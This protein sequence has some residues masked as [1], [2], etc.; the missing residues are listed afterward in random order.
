MVWGHLSCLGLSPA[1]A[2]NTHKI[3]S[4]QELLMNTHSLICTL[5]LLPMQLPVITDLRNPSLKPRHWNL[6]EEII[7]HKF[8]PN[9]PLTL[10]LMVDL[11]VFEYAE[12]IR[13]VSGQASSEASLEA[14][15]KKVSHT[16]SESAKALT[17]NSLAILCIICAHTSTPTCSHAH[18]AYTHVHATHTHTHAPSPLRLKM[19]GRLLSLLCFHTVSPRMCLSLV[20]QM[21]SKCCWMTV[22]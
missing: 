3:P 4:P 18:H 2:V 17:L 20:G 9:V 12:A 11:R 14:I 7:Q 5:S 8:D 10:Q 16:S 22:R 15:L 6:I 1:A 13:E 21:T 19:H